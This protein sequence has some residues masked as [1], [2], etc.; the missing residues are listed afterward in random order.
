MRLC[1]NALIILAALLALLF[2]ACDKVSEEDAYFALLEDVYGEDF[3]VKMPH[4]DGYGILMPYPLPDVYPYSEGDRL[5]AIPVEER[6][7]NGWEVCSRFEHYSGND[8]TL[9]PAAKSFKKGSIVTLVLSNNSSDPADVIVHSFGYHI[10]MLVD[11]QWEYVC[12]TDPPGMT[13]PSDVYPGKDYEI[14]I[15]NTTLCVRRLYGYNETTDTYYYDFP[16]NREV[17]L[18]AGRYRVTKCIDRPELC[19]LTCEFEITE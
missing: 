9:S 1:K 3:V 11:G 6:A 2:S 7:G 13:A 4:H 16:E 14:R 10:E 15:D 5:I 17:I 12:D 19:L 8:I 18:P